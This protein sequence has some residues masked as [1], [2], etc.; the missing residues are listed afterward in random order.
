MLYIAGEI[1]FGIVRWATREVYFDQSSSST[2]VAAGAVGFFDL[3]SD[4]IDRTDSV[5]PCASTRCP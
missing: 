3:A 5:S 4:G 2:R 1:H